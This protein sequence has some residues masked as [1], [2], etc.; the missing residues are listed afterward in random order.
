[1]IS[2]L[3]KLG[4]SRGLLR[5]LNLHDLHLPVWLMSTKPKEKT[6]CF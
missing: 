4:V 6:G 3:L 5:H 2:N 1:M